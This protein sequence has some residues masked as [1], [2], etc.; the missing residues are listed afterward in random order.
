[1]FVLIHSTFEFTGHEDSIQRQV[2][3]SMLLEFSTKELGEKGAAER[4]LRRRACYV[5][6]WSTR[7]NSF[8]ASSDT[9]QSYPMN[10]TPGRADSSSWYRIAPLLLRN[11]RSPFSS[12]ELPPRFWEFCS[13]RPR[14][15]SERHSEV[16]HTAVCWL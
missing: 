1:M 15:L 13:C 12:F 7:T 3:L 9:P 6:S 16:I 14:I 2:V 10:I 8:I 5:A 11:F 4:Q